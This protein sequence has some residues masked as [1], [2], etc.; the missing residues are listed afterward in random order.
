MLAACAGGGS[1]PQPSLMP[2]APGNRAGAITRL[3]RGH[4]WMAPEA[5]EKDLI[6]ISDLIAQVVD[7][8][9]YGPGHKL[10]GTLTG[11]FNPEGLCV[12]KAGD[13]FVVNDTSGGVHQITEYAHGGT[14]PIQ[15]LVNPNGNVNGCSVDLKSGDLAVTNFWGPT[16]GTG[17]VSIYKHATGNPTSYTDPN[18]YYYYYDGYDNKGNL[19]VSGLSYASQQGFAELPNGGSAFTDIALNQTIYLPGGVQWDGKYMAVGDQVAVKRNFT[20]VIYQFSISGSAGTE[21]G[22]TTL[23]GSNQVA[24]FWIPKVGMGKK[25]G[26]TVIAPNQGGKD[27][28]FFDYPAGGSPI[29][30]ILGETDPIGSTVSLAKK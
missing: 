27:T 20:S 28:L 1:P 13:V 18:I 7:I 17:G 15:N 2:P 16:E 19:F 26:T 6:Y 4:S 12:D 21:V 10:V 8:Y 25:G 3:D 29:G 14:S 11:F 30:T 5:K 9:T 22:V 24:Q 23:A